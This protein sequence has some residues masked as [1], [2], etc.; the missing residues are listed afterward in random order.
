MK[1][2][3][4]LLTGGGSGGHVY[5]L[6]AVARQLRE[7]AA[8]EGREMDLRYFGPPSVFSSML[9]GEGILASRIAAGKWRRYF[10]LLNF[11]DWPRSVWGFLQALFKIFWFMP[12]VVFSTGGPGSLATAY[13]CR[14]YWIP[15][16]AHESDAAPSLSNRL[17]SRFARSMTVGFASAAAGFKSVTS[18]PVAVTG[19]PVRDELTRLVDPA[20][21]RR[22]FGL[23]PNQPTLLIIGGSQGAARINEFIFNN[24][25][26]LLARYQIIHQVGSQNY[27]AY[28][29]ALKEGSAAGHPERYYVAAYFE[30]NFPEAYAAA[31]LVIA[32]AGAGTIFE[33]AALGKPA[34]LIP[35][36]EAAQD[37]QRENAY[38]YAQTGAA[39]IIEQENLLINLFEQE[40]DRLLG[41]PGRLLEMAD[42]ARRFSR[43]SAARDI[44]KIVLDIV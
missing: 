30:N 24:A 26:Q 36:P 39:I 34:I 11:L 32:R 13:A 33:L 28:Q 43:P 18:T 16:A 35:L 4:V 40:I 44:A 23:D 3:R 1:K 7:I 10:S 9:V 6:L 8:A 19:N 27:E 14:C 5:P 21:G 38:Q 42:A 25:E 15:V 20:E 37:H 41:N 22:F 31:D 12:D 29:L 2:L 17:V